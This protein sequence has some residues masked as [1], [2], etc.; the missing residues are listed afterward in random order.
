MNDMN[1]ESNVSIYGSENNVEDFPVLKAFQQY[2]D[3]EQVKARKRMMALCGVFG[4]IVLILLAVFAAMFFF[5]NGQTQE[6]ANRNQQLNDKL[7]EYLSQDRQQLTT[8]SSTAADTAIKA[9]T[10]SMAT[11]QKQIANQQ[12]A[13]LAAA[14]DEAAKRANSAFDLPSPEQQAAAERLRAEQQ[15][16][17]AAKEQ[18]A[19]DRETLHQ[20]EVEYHRRRLYP[21]LYEPRRASEVVPVE[22][23]PARA[24]KQRSYYQEE[25]SDDDDDL[26][27]VNDELGDE[28]SADEEEKVTPPKK[29]SETAK[30]KAKAPAEDK[31]LEPSP[32]PDLKSDGPI[33]YFKEEDFEIPVEVKGKGKPASKWRIPVK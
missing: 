13:T 3:A 20:R 1:N 4:F 32:L 12:S 9:M 10:E 31:D 16:L 14:R 27:D 26:E 29:K 21:E 23:P 5:L 17:A 11:L 15:A 19:R 33:E 25:P 30:P 18:L 24:T 7:F 8:A 22:R 2:I 6:L 28:A